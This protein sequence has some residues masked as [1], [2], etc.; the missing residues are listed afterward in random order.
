MNVDHQ[1]I[2]RSSASSDAERL[3][4]EDARS[5]LI[6]GINLLLSTRPGDV[7]DKPMN[8]ATFR[9]AWAAGQAMS[10]DEAVAFALQDT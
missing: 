1:F 9:Q 6:T 7:I 2:Q 5:S 4:S 8:D 3:A 10:L